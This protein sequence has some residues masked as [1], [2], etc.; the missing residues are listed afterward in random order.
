M[1]TEP[2]CIMGWPI[3]THGHRRGRWFMGWPIPS[4]GFWRVHGFMGWPIPT[5]GHRRAHWFTGWPTP[6]HGLW[7]GQWFMGWPIPTYGHRR[8]P[9]G[10]PLESPQLPI[11]PQPPTPLRPPQLNHTTINPTIPPP[12]PP[13]R[14]ALPAH[15]GEGA[16][17]LVQLPA[18]AGWE[19]GL[20][21]FLDGEEVHGVGEDVTPQLI[22]IGALRTGGDGTA[23]L[24]RVSNAF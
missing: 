10:Q 16:A 6:S 21:Q 19:D 14:A 13:P 7:R 15:R 22:P 18:F 5:N 3:Q 23:E 12:R 24:Q 17:P 4:H 11:P 2:Q 20:H 9:N 8:A 1:A